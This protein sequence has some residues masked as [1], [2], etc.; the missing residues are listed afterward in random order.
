MDR[1]VGPVDRINN[2]KKKVLEP[3]FRGYLF[4]HIDL[5]FVLPVLQTP[6]VV[7]VVGLGG[8]V[9]PIPDDQI[10]GV[11][12]AVTRPALAKRESSL[13]PGERVKV[14]SGPFQGLRGAVLHVRG[15]TR[16]AVA[17]EAIGQ[18]VSVEVHPDMIAKM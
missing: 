15:T 5:R 8:Q 9:C 6:G 14:V 2:R 18:S 11:R 13:I 1:V 3:L 17:L 16:V 12:I 4:V 10:E 7:R